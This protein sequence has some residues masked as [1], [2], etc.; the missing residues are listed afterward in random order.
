MMFQPVERDPDIDLL[1]KLVSQI[2]A[3]TEHVHEK[4]THI[5]KLAAQTEW[6]FY[7]RKEAALHPEGDIEFDMSELPLLVEQ[8][9]RYLAELERADRMLCGSIERL[10]VIKKD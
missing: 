9:R 5:Q 3:G 1:F 4:C 10:D 6:E 2:M 7:L 8:A